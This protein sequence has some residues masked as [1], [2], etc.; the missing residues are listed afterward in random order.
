MENYTRELFA[1]DNRKEFVLDF[2]AEYAGYAKKG[3]NPEQKFKDL[4]KSPRLVQ[5]V[6]KSLV[7]RK[8]KKNHYGQLIPVE[9]VEKIL[10]VVDSIIRIP[11]ICR[12][13]TVGK[14]ERY[15]FAI[16][17]VVKD[18]VAE[19]PDFST[20]FD[21]VDKDEFM[22]ELKK[23]DEKGMIHSVWTFKAPFI[24]GICNCDQ[25]CLAY[26]SRVNYNIPLFF[27]AEYVARIDWDK[28]TGCKSC[29]MV[30]QFGA[31]SYSLA[32]DRCEIDLKSCFGC[33]VCRAACPNQAIDLIDRTSVPE[34]VNNW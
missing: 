1:Q 25:D 8:Y 14:E 32:N 34:L 17:A 19:S 16:T 30:C 10:P 27:K 15:C 13:V 20:K 7:V 12:M 11:C 33:G 2:L 31:I 24:G 23:F 21:V 28:C 5:K 22:K 26:K 18:T 9:E 3:I 6:V 4:E 29:K